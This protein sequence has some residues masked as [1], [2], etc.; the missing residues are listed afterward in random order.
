M[1]KEKLQKNRP[2]FLV[3]FEG[4]EGSGKSTQL[5]LLADD[6]VAKGH[7]VL[8]T[9][10]PGGTPIG[11]TIRAILLD[12]A[13]AEMVPKAEL[14]LILASRAQHIVEVIRP[15]IAEGKI[16]LCDRFVH[17]TI[18]YQ[19]YGRG[20]PPSFVESMARHAAESLR[21]RVT[22][23]LDLEVSIALDR[24]ARRGELSRIDRET[25]AFHGRVREGYLK[26]ANK[27]K[28]ITRRID[29]ARPV[30]AV[31]REIREQMDLLHV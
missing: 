28:R 9:R 16:V 2:G 21:P 6:L 11:N 4:I 20:L 17:A 29:A 14:F 5:E 3:T 8:K 10:E 1:P 24:L 31:A 7:P 25:L 18:A 23:L 26:I 12:P 30:E 19:G 27:L 15:A 22:F 13:R